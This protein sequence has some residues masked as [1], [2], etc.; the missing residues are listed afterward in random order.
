MDSQPRHGF[1][2][3]A[4]PTVVWRPVALYMALGATISALVVFSSLDVVG[5]RREAITD[6][7]RLS[8]LLGGVLVAIT[9]PGWLWIA[10]RTSYAVEAGKLHIVAGRR[11]NGSWDL[12]SLSAVSLGTSPSWIDLLTPF[13]IAGGLFP[14]ASFISDAERVSGR[15]IMLWGHSAT[16]SAE[17][18]LLAAI[19]LSR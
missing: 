6:F 15:P 9:V 2:L 12:S 13:N 19:A 16:R 5:S 18:A 11:V 10:G 7:L 17:H 8:L 14:R 4:N 1:A 3:R